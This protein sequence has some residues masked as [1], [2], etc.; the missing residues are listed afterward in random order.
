MR[1]AKEASVTL[2]FH[3]IVKKK[4]RAKGHSFAAPRGTKD[5]QGASRN[6][7]DATARQEG[8]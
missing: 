5:A 7:A 6:G 2:K 8:G 3:Q 4:G 1:K